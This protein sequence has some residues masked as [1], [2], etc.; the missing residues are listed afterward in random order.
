MFEGEAR[1][2]HLSRCGPASCFAAGVE[3]GGTGQVAV[4]KQPAGVNRFKR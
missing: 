4:P 1:L 2:Q 3:E